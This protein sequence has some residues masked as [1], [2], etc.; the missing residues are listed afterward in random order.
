MSNKKASIE[1]SENPINYY[2]LK[3]DAVNDLVSALNEEAVEETHSVHKKYVREKKENQPDPYKLDKLALV[4]TWIK[5]IFVKFWVAGAI[6]YFFIWGLG[7]QVS[8]PLD[9]VFLTGIATGVIFDLLVNSAFLYFESDKKE[10]HPYILVPVPAKKIWSLLINIPVSLIEVGLVMLIYSSI[11]ILIKDLKGLPEGST[12]LNVEPIL[13]GVFFV[14][15][16]MA[17][18]SIKN[19]IIKVYKKMKKI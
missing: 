13:Y 3:T 1:D 16:D 15:V 5:A 17:I 12:V 19:L 6:C 14:I 18:I 10:Y 2:D 8:D 4:P 7:I 9:Q 11:N